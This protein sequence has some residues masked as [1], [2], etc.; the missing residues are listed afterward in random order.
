MPQRWFNSSI[1]PNFFRSCAVELETISVV[2]LVMSSATLLLTK[3][4][5]PL[6]MIVGPGKIF[7]AVSVTVPL[8]S[9]M[10]EVKSTM[11]CETTMVSSPPSVRS[12]APFTELVP[13]GFSVSCEFVSAL[14]RLS[15]A[16]VMRLA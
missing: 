8:P 10:S 14:I 3:R 9:F 16:S 2:L 1:V 6:L 4:N 12:N 7:V 13:D 11:G 15:L 5:V